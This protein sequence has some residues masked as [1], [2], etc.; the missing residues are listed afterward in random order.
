MSRQSSRIGVGSADQPHAVCHHPAAATLG[1]VTVQPSAVIFDLGGVLIDWNPRYLYRKLFAGDDEAME[2]FL[3]EVT[4]PAWNAEQDAG[5]TWREA[6]DALAAIHPDRRDLIEAYD[7]R[8]AETLGGPI[9]GTVEILT[10]LRAAGVRLAA[11]SNWSAEKFPIARPR[12][13]FLE[14]VETIVIS[15]EVG[16]AKPDPRIFGHLLELT[17]LTARTTVFV[18][19]V[20]ANVDAAAALGMI[21][22]R[23]TDPATLRRDLTALRLLGAGVQ[24]PSG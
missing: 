10:E 24:R 7:E 6:V 18:D 15:G 14:W 21:A 4:S 8:W 11:L 3:A 5:R 13:P 9:E 22:L 1:H 23:F 16:I 20:P 12:Y 19:D 17:G 2:V